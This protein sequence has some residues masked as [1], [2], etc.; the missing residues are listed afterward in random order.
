[1]FFF[2]FL[3]SQPSLPISGISTVTKAVSSVGFVVTNIPRDALSKIL[4]G[5]IEKS[6]ERWHPRRVDP[7]KIQLKSHSLIGVFFKHSAVL[8]F[9]ADTGRKQTFLK[10]KSANKP[11]G[12]FSLRRR[13]WI[14]WSSV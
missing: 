12:L 6:K 10:G 3:T 13:P 5:F 14:D 2:S 7:S 11:F 8:P 9:L 1:M 4:Y